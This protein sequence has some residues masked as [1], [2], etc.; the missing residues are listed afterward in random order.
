MNL[1]PVYSRFRVLKLEDMIKM[2]FAKFIFKYRYCN[3]MLPNSFSNYF[4]KLK[5]IC[6]NI[7]YYCRQ[8]RRNEYFRTSFVTETEKKHCIRLPRFE[9]RAKYSETISSMF[10]HKNLRNFV[11]ISYFLYN[12]IRSSMCL[13]Y[14]N[15]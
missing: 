1:L 12:Y 7:G 13:T 8:K 3:N 2:K 9:R 15:I 6:N 5:N 4:I 11:K 14:R 10:F